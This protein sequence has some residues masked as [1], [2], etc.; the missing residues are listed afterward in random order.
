LKKDRRREEPRCPTGRI[1]KKGRNRE[2]KRSVGV[3]CPTRRR[4]PSRP[5]KVES[6]RRK[7]GTEEKTTE[8]RRETEGENRVDPMQRNYFGLAM[9]LQTSGESVGEFDQRKHVKKD[10]HIAKRTVKTGCRKLQVKKKKKGR[11][12]RKGGGVCTTQPPR[13]DT[14]QKFRRPINLF[15]SWPGD[16]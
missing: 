13:W 15:N 14:I 6:P 5:L 11:E 8:G 7:G 3:R 9:T 16:Q 2:E 1:R 10:C 4:W 12:K